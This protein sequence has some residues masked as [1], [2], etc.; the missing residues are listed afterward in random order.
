MAQGGR[1]K[2]PIHIQELGSGEIARQPPVAQRQYLVKKE[3]GRAREFSEP[4][5]R[6]CRAHTAGLATIL[7]TRVSKNAVRE[8]YVA[9]EGE[10]KRLDRWLPESSVG[11]EVL[12][13]AVSGLAR[14]LEAVSVSVGC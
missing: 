3:D 1:L 10:D 5:Q 6:R 8:V 2:S 12:D 11:E 4:S 13:A 9:F 7:D 14:A